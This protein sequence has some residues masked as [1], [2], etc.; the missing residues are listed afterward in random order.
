MTSDLVGNENAVVVVTC[1][2]A[3]IF[4]LNGLVGISEVTPSTWTS[5]FRTSKESSPEI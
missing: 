2:T 4:I 1:G 3:A 5:S